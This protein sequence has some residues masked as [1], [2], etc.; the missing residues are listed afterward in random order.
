MIGL[1]F[2]LRIDPAFTPAVGLQHQ[3]TSGAAEVDLTDIIAQLEAPTTDAINEQL[4]EAV[5]AFNQRNFVD[6]KSMVERVLIELPG[7]QE[8]RALLAQLEQALKVEHQVGQFLA[9]A[10]EALAQGDAQEASNFV[11]M[12]QALDPHHSGIAATLQEIYAK[13]GLPQHDESAGGARRD[14]G[15]FDT[16]DTPD[17]VEM[18][19]EGAG[20][21]AWGADGGQEFSFDA[22]PA[23]GPLDGAQFPPPD[24]GAAQIGGDAL[25][26]PVDASFAQTPP[27][28]HE[29][30]ADDV[31]D[32]FD[33][34]SGQTAAP[35][36]GELSEAQGLVAR[37]TAAYESGLFLAA[38]DAW[39][40]VYL[41]D[42]SNSE[43][44]ALIEAAKKELAE[45]SRE[46][47][48]LLFDAEDAVISGETDKALELVRR[49]LAQNPGHPEA[50]ELQQ[51]L[52]G[53]SSPA[54]APAKAEPTAD[55]MPDLEDDLFSEPFDEIDTEVEPEVEDDLDDFPDDSAPKRRSKLLGLSGRALAVAAVAAIVLM[56]V[57]WFG[58]RSLVG[59][60]ES[61]SSGDV[62][63]MKAE[64]Q[65]LFKQGDVVGAIAMVEQFE[66]GD[67][68]DEQLVNMLLTKYQAALATPT[69]TPVPAAAIEARE[70]LTAG[71]WY[72]AYLTATSGLE[73]HP[74][75]GGLQEIIE[76]IEGMEPSV[77]TL[78]TQIA[79][80]NHRGA[81]STARS[82]LVN[83]PDQPDLVL[84]LGQS[85]FNASL[86]E[87]R[88]YNLTGA[89]T[90][91]NELQGLDPSDEEVAR[92]LEFVQKYKA[93]PVDMQLRVFI[94]SLGER[95]GWAELTEA[96]V[97]ATGDAAATPTPT[98]DAPTA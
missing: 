36:T 13:G 54:A 8:A 68:I 26:E 77:T 56:V 72:R 45:S 48:H 6:S 74:S 59:G 40:R 20:E 60:S 57:V 7:H 82:V 79:N 87:L 12:A 90:Y 75:D 91:L 80:G 92:V 86:A 38:I 18:Q 89:S 62:Y 50:L 39:S 83:Y 84:V 95:S 1:E 73:D 15:P 27:A 70:L 4:V 9:Q 10:R 22:E 33:A 29:P 76:Q 67:E 47:E 32:L 44:P 97:E 55:A 69:P 34:D 19:D 14:P 5:E 81:M 46:V 25:T 65:A 94:Q 23:A 28:E 17:G 96:Q 93:R 63:A 66:P 61:S 98:P 71:L 64:A 42:P 49:V 53:G 11:M 88:T 43:V 31:S 37:G 21:P 16:P 52:S 2:V 51:R 41:A 58:L 78:S 35:L 24:M 85:L 3:L 30:P